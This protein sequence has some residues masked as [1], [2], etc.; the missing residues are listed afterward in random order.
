[1]E[2]KTRN[3]FNF[4]DFAKIQKNVKEK[5]FIWAADKY[6]SKFV[7]KNSN[8]I[9]YKFLCLAKKLQPNKMAKQVIVFF[10][11]FL[12]FFLANSFFFTFFTFYLKPFLSLVF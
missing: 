5:V 8:K 10:H 1:M 9:K 11:T 7:G 12:F 4:L 6:F 3:I 2:K